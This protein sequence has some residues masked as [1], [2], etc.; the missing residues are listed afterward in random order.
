MKLSRPFPRP[1][2][3][4]KSSRAL[5]WNSKNMVSKYFCTNHKKTH[6]S[7][8]FSQSNKPTTKCVEDKETL[9]RLFITAMLRYTSVVL[10]FH[11]GDD[12]QVH[13]EVHIEAH[14]QVHQRRVHC[15][16]DPFHACWCCRAD[17]WEF[18]FKDILFGL[19]LSYISLLVKLS[20][21]NIVFPSVL[22]PILRVIFILWEMFIEVVD[23][24][25]HLDFTEIKWS[26][27]LT[28]WRLWL[29]KRCSIFFFSLI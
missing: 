12:G 11:H 21:S 10:H 17:R 6:I 23:L 8:F 14:V 5:S 24:S 26:F 28:D 16:P 29:Q 9:F 27:R 19:N 1:L 18:A 3:Q 7:S 2:P 25:K 13:V 20:C 15:Q 4:S 22:I